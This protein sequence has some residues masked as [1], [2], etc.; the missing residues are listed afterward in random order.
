MATVAVL[1][2]VDVGHGDDLGV[3]AVRVDNA[4][5]PLLRG[6]AHPDHVGRVQHL[7]P[8]VLQ[9]PEQLLEPCGRR[10]RP[11]PRLCWSW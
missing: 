8:R 5:E 3:A 6:L 4:P 2:P 11:R 10:R 1:A 9:L 7:E